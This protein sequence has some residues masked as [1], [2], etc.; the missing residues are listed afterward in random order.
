[1]NKGAE[2][3]HTDDD[4]RQGASHIVVRAGHG[5][6][7]DGGGQQGEA[8]GGDASG[9]FPARW[10]A[11]GLAGRQQ[12]AYGRNQQQRL[13]RKGPVGA[14]PYA[15]GGE[16]AADHGTGESRDHPHRRQAGH[17]PR[18]QV[19]G[20]EAVLADID[21]RHQAAAAQALQHAAAENH[22][23]AQGQ[24]A[25]H[26]TEQI[27]QCRTQ[28]GSAQ[29]VARHQQAGTGAGDDR[30]HQVQG[31]GPVQQVQAA[32]LAHRR[33][34]GGG[35]E[36]GIGGMQPQRHGQGGELGQVAAVEQF[37]PADV[38]RV[39][40]RAVLH[41]AVHRPDLGSHLR[42]TMPSARCTSRT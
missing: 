37:A 7:Q 38:V 26:A 23:H 24:G 15:P 18:H 31:E 40:G 33:G 13:E 4:V 6:Q 30:S 36:H 10:F 34:H 21:Q 41:R 19:I 35:G 8:H 20:E 5:N 1:M 27:H 16:G 11:A 42:F 3:H 39:A 22:R 14:A 2:H 25:D 29:A 32:D 28:H 9:I 12:G 17:H